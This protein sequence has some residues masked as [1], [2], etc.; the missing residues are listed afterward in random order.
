M[1]VFVCE[2]NP[3][4]NVKLATVFEH[5]NFHIM[6]LSYFVCD[7]LAAVLYQYEHKVCSPV[8][9]FAIE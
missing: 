2:I 9:Y 1:D 5:W 7:F 6:D 3:F 4:G 8:I